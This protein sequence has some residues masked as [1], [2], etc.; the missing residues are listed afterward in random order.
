MNYYAARE[1]R[2]PDTGASK[3]WHYTVMND[4]RIR[5]IGYCAGYPNFEKWIKDGIMPERL[6]QREMEKSEPHKGRYHTEF[7]MTKEGAEECYQDYL[8][9]HTFRVSTVE[10]PKCKHCGCVTDQVV[11]LDQWEVGS[12]CEAHQ[13]IQFLK[14]HHPQLLTVRTVAG[15]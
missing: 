10:L 15:S 3:G 6:I 7:H 14:E 9:D 2:H 12:F 13:S 5:P 4:G 8:I 1:S 11:Y